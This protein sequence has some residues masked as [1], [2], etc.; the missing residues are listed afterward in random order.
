MSK[1]LSRPSGRSTASHSICTDCVHDGNCVFQRSSCT[2]ILFCE[3]HEVERKQEEPVRATM[4][5]G[6]RTPVVPGLCGSC[7]HIEHCA[8]RDPE[9]ITYHCEHYE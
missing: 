3:E 8:L 1:T 6:V 5:N 7:I 4:V 9:R 2:P